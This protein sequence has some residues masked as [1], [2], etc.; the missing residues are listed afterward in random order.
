M[1][2]NYKKMKKI[3]MKTLVIKLKDIETAHKFV[4]HFI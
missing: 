4:F 3:Y 2:S 1:L